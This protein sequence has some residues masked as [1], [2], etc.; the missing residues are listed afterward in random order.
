[1]PSL[2]SHKWHDITTEGG[3]RFDERKEN[4]EDAG[5][6]CCSVSAMLHPDGRVLVSEKFIK[7]EYNYEESD[8]QGEITP[9]EGGDGS[10][11]G[12]Y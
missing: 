5:W 9:T 3:R 7:T 12:V 1:M 6:T 10:D 4:L 8:I 11:Q 2:I